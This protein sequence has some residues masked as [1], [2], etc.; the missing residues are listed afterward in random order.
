M[1]VCR[2]GFGG[3]WFRGET[4]LA[5]NRREPLENGNFLLRGP[6]RTGAV[7]KGTP[8]LVDSIKD[9]DFAEQLS[10]VSL[11][12]LMGL[13]CCDTPNGKIN[14]SIPDNRVNFG[15]HGIKERNLPAQYNCQI[16]PGH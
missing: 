8:Y 12:F 3:R 10:K 5:S 16:V 14:I 15:F 13:L 4:G 2:C 9:D 7:I 11:Q 6:G 1:P